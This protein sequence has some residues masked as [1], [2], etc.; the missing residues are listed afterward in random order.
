MADASIT[1]KTDLDNSDLEKQ[2][3]DAEKSI[4]SLKGK[5]ENQEL[6]KSFLEKMMERADK[7]IKKTESRL[8]ELKQQQSALREEQGTLDVHD[9]ADSARFEEISA[10]TEKVASSIDAAY[11]DLFSYYDEWNKLSDKWDVANAKATTYEERL[12]EVGERQKRLGAELAEERSRA[13]VNI[14]QS[15]TTIKS[16]FAEIAE[17][18]RQRMADAAQ[19]SATPWEQFGKRIKSMLKRVFAFSVILKGLNA[20]KNAIGSM[21]SSNSQLNASVEN[22]KAVLRGFLSQVVSALV[23]LLTQAASVLAGAFERIAQIIDSIFGTNIVGAISQQRADASAA[24]QAEN[25]QRMAEYNEQVAESQNAQAR[26]AQRQ[27]QAAKKLEEAQ[28]KA[29][30]QL[31]S[32][33]ELNKMAEESSE[34]LADEVEDSADDGGYVPFPEL[35]NDWT[36]ALSPTDGALQGIFEWLDKI[37]DRILNDVDGPFARIREGL[38]LIKQGWD[39]LLQGFA[40]GDLGLIWQGIGDIIIGALY[41]IEGAISA[42]LDWLDEITGGRF[43]EIFEGMKLTIH[44]FVEF[45]EGLLRGDL[46]LAFQ[47]LN[48]MVDG[49]GMTMKGVISSV[50]GAFHDA[51]D[52]ALAELKKKLPQFEGLFNVTGEFLHGLIDNISNYL[53]QKIDGDVE[54][55]H[56][57]LEMLEGVFSLSFDKFLSGFR[58]VSDGIQSNIRALFD[59]IQNM[60]NSASDFLR[61]AITG[62]F[63]FL[64]QQFPQARWLF[65]GFKTFLLGIGSAIHGA[66]TGIIHGISN[67]LQSTLDGIMQM[68][69]GNLNLLVGII[70]L[71]GER[72]VNGLKGIVNG[73][74]TVVEGILDSVI[75][76]VVDF[77]NGII[78]GLSMIPG[79]YIPSITFHGVNL[80]RLAQGAVIPPNREFMA[81][82]GDQKQGTNIEAPESLMRQVVR[83]ET[84]PLLADMVAALLT[85]NIGSSSNGSERDLVLMVDRKELARE[86]LR[87]ISELRDTGELSAMSGLAYQG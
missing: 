61:N 82:L 8:A 48:D 57:V 23:P 36:Q 66:I 17:G 5:L 13:A 12:N 42:F 70:T 2:L 16:R 83:E 81:I 20:I 46:G 24:I 72:V 86:T 76:G 55:I 21:L 62:V 35:Q 68:I 29:N 79:V 19:R 67:Y 53:Q 74:I 78:D 85:A 37:R 84:G 69:E 75:Y 32:F 18:I 63:D 6:E 60:V 27:A 7:S 59:F 39:E 9:P 30:Q 26:A 58:R 80:P 4:N 44:G 77:V 56:G 64:S 54:I 43:H 47:G 73:F 22:L 15:G 71:D 65:E 41:I 40:N 45:V 33:D 3:R 28:K 11:K 34:D 87:G 38:E 49:V 25:A 10:E 50:T 31:F 52:G 1:F 14:E 51:L